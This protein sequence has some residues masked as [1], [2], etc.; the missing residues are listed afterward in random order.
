M[1]RSIGDYY[2]HRFGIS[3]KPE[4]ISVDLAEV[5]T[6]P[7]HPPGA[8]PHPHRLTLTLFE[9]SACTCPHTPDAVPLKHVTH[10]RPNLTQ[11]EMPIP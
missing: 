10:L 7:K 4:V 9:L 3:W 5:T 1:T 2:M 8:L 11:L 6:P